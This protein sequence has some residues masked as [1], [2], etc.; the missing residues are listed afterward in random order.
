MAP[1]PPAYLPV[2]PPSIPGDIHEGGAEVDI[3]PPFIPVP[4]CAKVE[5]RFLEA[6]Q[7]ME[8]VFYLFKTGGYASS[9]LTTLATTVYNSWNDNLRDTWSDTTGLTQIKCSDM[10]T[11]YGA[12]Y[13]LDINPY[14]YGVRTGTAATSASCVGISFHTGFRGKGNNGRLFAGGAMDVDFVNSVPTD[15]ART[16]I[17]AAYVDFFTDLNTAGNFLVIASFK[18]NKQWRST[19]QVTTVWYLG[20]GDW[21]YTAR[22]RLPGHNRHR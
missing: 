11:R 8:N 19:A 14:E 22:R 20:V 18:L 17:R 10:S 13:E 2:T 3:K 1:L 4:L 6:N 5:M 21:I 15:A 9:D 12:Y 7:P 16:G